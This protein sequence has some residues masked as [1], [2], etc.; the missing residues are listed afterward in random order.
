[1]VTT[2]TLCV[3]MVVALGM[4]LGY[5][6]CTIVLSSNWLLNSDIFQMLGG[7]I[8]NHTGGYNATNKIYSQETLIPL[9]ANSL[10]ND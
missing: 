3:V 5:L 1:M 9:W 8:S 10:S 4:K 2:L 7:Y 6:R